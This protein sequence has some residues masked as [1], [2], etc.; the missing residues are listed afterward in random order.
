MKRVLVL[1]ITAGCLFGI[2][3]CGTDPRDE[4]LDKTIRILQNVTS[5]LQ[6]IDDTL[7][8]AIDKA[9]KDK[10]PIGSQDNKID[11]VL[12]AAKEIKDR[13][14]DLQTWKDAVDY[15][16]ESTSESQKKRLSDNWRSQLI[17]AIKNRWQV[18]QKVSKLIPQAYA[19]ADEKGRK[20][21]EDLRE[22]LNQGREPYEL[23]N[24]QR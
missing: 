22:A 14:K 16:K 23:I 3:G 1:A 8:K 5:S 7:T 13:G 4:A 2:L 20:T 9:K 19:L 17:T 24:R 18:D 12:R 11:D 15:L 6:S 10:A 21:L